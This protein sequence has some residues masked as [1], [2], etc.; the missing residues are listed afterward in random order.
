MTIRA[1]PLERVVKPERVL[2]SKAFAMILLC[3]VGLLFGLI[4]KHSFIN[5]MIEKISKL[6]S[7][8]DNNG[9]LQK[10]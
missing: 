1:R 7:E 9:S 4:L 8:S 6:R 5:K 2:F 10:V 3:P